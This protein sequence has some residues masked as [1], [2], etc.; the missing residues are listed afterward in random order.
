MLA[1]LVLALLFPLSTNDLV[2][3]EEDG[4]R[5]R[6]AEGLRGL[7]IDDQLELHRLLDGDVG[8]LGAF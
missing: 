1:D 2:R 8:W 3:P 4:L 5:D 6:E 7:E